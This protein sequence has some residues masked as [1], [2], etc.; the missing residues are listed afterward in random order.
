MQRVQYT[1]AAA[2]LSGRSGPAALSEVGIGFVALRDVDGH[3]R[4]VPLPRLVRARHRLYLVATLN[5][6]ND[7][8]LASPDRLALAA[9]GPIVLHRAIPA[10]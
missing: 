8:R 7:A 6:Q 4:D 9:L 5:A 10:R 1:A 3:R 2:S